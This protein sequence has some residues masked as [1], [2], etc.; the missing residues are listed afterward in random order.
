MSRKLTNGVRKEPAEWTQV[1]TLRLT[2]AI[3][4]ALTKYIGKHRQ[5]RS[6][7]IR[8]ILGRHL[9]VPKEHRHGYMSNSINRGAGRRGE[10]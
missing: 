1:K 10:A 7:V 8:E 6:W 2:E 3:D 5:S 9:S 4:A